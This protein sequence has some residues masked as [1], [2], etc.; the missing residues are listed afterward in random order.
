MAKVT[1]EEYAE[2]WGRRLKGATEDVR[3]GVERVTEAPGKKAAQAADRMLAGV[4]EAVSSGVWQRQVAGVSLEDWKDSTIKKGLQRIAQGVDEAL[5]AQR[6]MAEKLLRAVDE[7]VARV[8]QIPRGTLEDN[9]NRAVT[10]MREMSE[11][12]P[13]KRG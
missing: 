10:F 9:I 5:P 4:Q 1:P 2:K 13:K 12:A 8:D 11:R 7:A 3:R 6:D